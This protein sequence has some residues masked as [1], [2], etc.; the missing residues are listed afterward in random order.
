LTRSV[1]FF[2]DMG[3]IAASGSPAA[4]RLFKDVLIASASVPGVFAPTYVEVE[5][6]GHRFREM[7][8]DGGA[9]TEVFT[10]PDAILVSGMGI[11][12]RGSAKAHL[13]VIINNH[14]TP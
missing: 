7:H 1:L 10:V 8:V 13:W 2:W 6:N 11:E 3:A 4:L 5:A 12:P 9:T 14:M